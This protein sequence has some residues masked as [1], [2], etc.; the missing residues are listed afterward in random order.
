MRK[1]FFIFA[2]LCASVMGWAAIDWDAVDYLGSTEPSISMNT[3]KYA[4]DT[5]EGEI[6]PD[7]IANIQPAAETGI[8]G[9]YT[10]YGPLNVVSCSH[11]GKISG[12]QLWVYVNQLEDKD[13]KITVTLSDASTRTFHL[14]NKNGN[15]GT[16]VDPSAPHASGKG[17][18]TYIAKDVPFYTRV[19]NKADD[20]QAPMGTADLYIVTYGNKMMAK[21]KLNGGATFLGNGYSM[22]FRIWN[23]AQTGFGE[24]WAQLRAENN[25]V[26]L[27]DM[28]SNYCNLNQGTRTELPFNTYMETSAGTGVVP[29]FM[30][31][32]DYINAPIVGDETAPVISSAVAS[33]SPITGEPTITI[34]ATDANDIFYKIVDPSNNVSY[35]F[36]NTLQLTTDGSNNVITY[37]IYAIDFN[38]NMSSGEAVEVQMKPALSNIALNK[39][40]TAGVNQSTTGRIV[41]GNFGGER[42]SSAGAI[43]YNPTTH[44]DDYQ[45]WFYINFVNIYDLSAVRI[46]WET[47]RP[48][49]Y[50]FRTS[51]DGTNWTT[52]ASFTEYPTANAIV[53]YVLPANTQGRFFGV[54]A[55]SGYENLNYGISPFE[56]EV[57]GAQAVIEDHNPPTLHSAV[58]S[59]D[60]EW[61]QVRIAVDAEDAEDP[62]IYVYHVVDATHSID[63]ECMVSEGI[64]T[65]TGLSGETTYN[66]SVKAV[67]GAGNESDAIVVNA[68][69]PMDT[70]VPLVAA[71]TPSGTNK[72][73][74]HIYSDAFPSTDGHSSCLAHDFKKDG[75]AGVALMQEKNISGD[76]CLIYNIAGAAEVTCGH[77]DG[78]S[79]AIIAADGYHH[80]SYAG[81]DASEMEYL[82][83]DIWSLQACS[84]INIQINDVSLNTKRSHDGT[85][86]NSYDI[87]LT[88]YTFGDTE[89]TRRANVRFMKFNGLAPIT[90]K[91][92]LDN[93]YFWK[94]A[95]GLKSVS[96]TPNNPVMGTATV[97]Q[98]SA[99]VTEVTTGSEVT[100][101]ATA[102]SGYDFAYWTINGDRVYTNPYTLAI[103]VNTNAVATFEPIRTAYCAEP[104]TDTEGRTL[105]LTISSPSA[106]TYKVLFEGSADN[107]IGSNDVYENTQFRLRNVNGVAVYHFAYK[108]DREASDW[109]VTAADE[110]SY[111]S[112]YILFTADDFR[113]ISVYQQGVDL[114]RAAGGL[115]SFNAFPDVSIIKWDATCTDDEAPELADPVA[116]P[117]SGTSV[118]LALS[119]T[120]N[121]AALLTYN[122]NYKPAGDAG[123]GTDIDVNGTAGETT[124]KNIKGL[125]AGVNYTFTVTASDGTNTSAAKTCSVTPTMQ[126]APVPTHNA[127]A[128]RSVYSDAYAS[129]LKHDFNKNTWVS[130]TFYTEQIIGGDHMLVYTSD[131]PT[132]MPQIAWGVDNDGDEAIIAKDEYAA[133]GDNK[134]LDVR[135]MDYIHFDIWST[136]ATTYPEV[137][138]NNT[139]ISGFALD[140]S[141]WQ[142][143]DLS[144]SSLTD[145]Q[146]INVRWIKFQ[147]LRTP[148]PEEIAIDNVYFWSYGTKTT[149]IMG[150][151]AETGGWATFA[152]SEKV[153]VPEGL[154]AYKAEYQKTATEEL[155]ELT[156]IGNV[157]P[158]NYGVI[159]KGTANT[160][161]TF[162]PTSD[163]EGDVS[164]NALV[165]CPTRTDISSVAANNDIFCLR[166]SELYSLTG[167]FL[168]TGQYI[169]AGKAYLPIPKDPG[170]AGLPQ[171]KIRFIFHNE[172]TTTGIENADAEA[173]QATKF[174]ENGQL[175]IRRGDAVY[176]IQGARVK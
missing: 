140:G 71:P 145:E 154:T 9:L 100:F 27:I 96:A 75:F 46:K 5:D 101:T 170:G 130:P 123:A 57:Y 112:A 53:D 45:D 85:G 127:V 104:V 32:L 157:I 65:V 146:K 148:N 63:Q 131:D 171:R 159:L 48:N 155:L 142:S 89:H 52:V 33:Y 160:V 13:T 26:A 152:A 151:D 97:K 161:Y 2:L 23:D 24:Y 83:V 69:T 173:V 129:A 90:G 114:I 44:P 166:Y 78:G 105:Y 74:V 6:G 108:G 122:V 132:S 3:Y 88:D 86:W 70:S 18:G 20:T 164:G 54:W 60:P 80:E 30:Y 38:G 67:D 37:T 22:Q 150:G 144:L 84:N 14:Y 28:N 56:V 147:G 58:L 133:G 47:A 16:P 169:P 29:M 4:V 121:M 36:S 124:Y 35:S 72:D 139:S 99:D 42:W 41:D 113:E 117:L 141:G 95:S 135:S 11:D 87:P 66:L 162:A 125:T 134:G 55:T 50:T 176:T 64:I 1:L 107:Q 149:P 81:I 73:V 31:T 115:S 156:D 92:A 62:A 168:Y 175:F 61:N 116:S 163:P 93:I 76:K 98:N 109:H 79:N 102:N 43:H 19:N 138:L 15:D 21:A 120:D 94:T 7:G 111:G 91:M 128:V 59:G 167:F 118:R 51:I 25:T 17:F 136:I 49:N 119:A 126:T 39:S 174:M 12:T 143:F 77:Y 34:T 8:L 137:T 10:H 106:N 82:H 40:V 68:T 110:N 172:Q 103:T 158:A 153:A 165:G